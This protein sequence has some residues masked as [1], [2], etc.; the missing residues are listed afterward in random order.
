MNIKIDS[1]EELIV[2]H[3]TIMTVKFD[4]D[5]GYSEA[6]GSPFSGSL[7]RK[8]FD[9]IVEFETGRGNQEKVNEWLKWQQADGSRRETKLLITTIGK[10]EWWNAASAEEKLVYVN[11][12][13]SP[14]VL[15]S[16]AMEEVCG[17]ETL[18]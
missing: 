7:A 11:D 16:S 5:S 12:F 3:K 2:L 8:V 17:V 14:L 10:S 9:L 4:E 6:Q 15:Q 13:M 1:Y 18:K